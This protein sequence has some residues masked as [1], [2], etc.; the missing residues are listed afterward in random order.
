MPCPLG[1]G[2]PATR[3]WFEPIFC[4]TCLS[5]CGA[6]SGLPPVYAGPPEDASARHLARIKPHQRCG[7]CSL[8]QDFVS[9][10]P[11]LSSRSWTDIKAGRAN[12]P[13]PSTRFRAKAENTNHRP[14][15]PWHGNGSYR[16][17][18]ALCHA[19]FGHIALSIP[20]SGSN[21]PAAERKAGQARPFRFRRRRPPCWA[22]P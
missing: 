18:R 7:T 10:P 17:S 21:T 3:R 9:P 8:G 20:H 12:P 22:R 6:K 14:T 1:S 4:Q 16:P 2:S 11:A 13:S 19:L 5:A 15:F